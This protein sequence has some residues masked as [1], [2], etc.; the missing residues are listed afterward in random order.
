ML[1]GLRGYEKMYSTVIGLHFLKFIKGSDFFSKFNE[2]WG[3][4]M[5]K[6]SE[7]KENG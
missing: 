7:K 5:S 3:G 1:G 2:F 6:L 4:F